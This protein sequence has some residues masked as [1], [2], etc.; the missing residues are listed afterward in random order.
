MLAAL[1][2][3]LALAL[4]LTA[5]LWHQH[6]HHRAACAAMAAWQYLDRSE[7]E[8]QGLL[9]RFAPE[10]SQAAAVSSALEM[11]RLLERKRSGA[12]HDIHSLANPEIHLVALAGSGAD[13]QVLDCAIARIDLDALQ[14]S[15]LLCDATSVQ[16][17]NCSFSAAVSR[18]GLR[19][20]LL[21]ENA[22]WAAPT[23]RWYL[24]LPMDTAL[25]LIHV[26]ESSAQK[27]IETVSPASI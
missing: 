15:G 1:S 12:R 6:Q 4:A 19:R 10:D 2:T 8:L 7:S 13:Y 26:Q 24:R 23:L 22:P 20:F 14:A 3:L 9:A 5:V 27:Q 21:A 16:A 25:I 11:K 18:E 17:G